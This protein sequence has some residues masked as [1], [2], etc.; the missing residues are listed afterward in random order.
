M[1]RTALLASLLALSALS[2]AAPP[3]SAAVGES[4]TVS[5]WT[6][7]ASV[8]C[9]GLFYESVILTWCPNHPTV[10]CFN[11][12]LL[13]CTVS[14]TRPFLLCPLLTPFLP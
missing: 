12:N 8:L 1:L 6:W 10:D 11:V 2:V 13:T 5:A 14:T 9:T 4:C 3:A 7:R